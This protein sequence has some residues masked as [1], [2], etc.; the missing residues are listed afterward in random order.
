MAG[1]GFHTAFSPHLQQRVSALENLTGSEKNSHY[2]Q[3]LAFALHIFH[4]EGMTIF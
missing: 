2:E 4:F 3:E 1:Y